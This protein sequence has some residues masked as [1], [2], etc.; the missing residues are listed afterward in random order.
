MAPCKILNRLIMKNLF[1]F[2]DYL[3]L[4]LT[5]EEVKQLGGLQ[6]LIAE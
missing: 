5:P 6:S 3:I 2:R 1:N 4:P